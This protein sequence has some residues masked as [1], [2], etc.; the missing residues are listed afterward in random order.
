MKC[1][2]CGMIHENTELHEIT[3]EIL[4]NVCRDCFDNNT[5]VIW[6]DMQNP[7]DWHWTTLRN[8]KISYASFWDELDDNDPFF[9]KIDVADFKE[10]NEM[11]MGCDYEIFRSEEAMREMY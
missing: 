6:V 7:S 8:A 2:A 10:F 5:N 3:H 4:S 1:D 9:K 11:L